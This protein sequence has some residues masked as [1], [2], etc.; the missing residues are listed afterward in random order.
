M[1][2]PPFGGR[3]VPNEVLGDSSARVG[4]QGGRATSFPSALGVKGIDPAERLKH[5]SNP[6][7]LKACDNHHVVGG[8]VIEAAGP[9]L[10]VQ[11]DTGCSTM[12]STSFWSS[13]ISLRA[14]SRLSHHRSGSKLE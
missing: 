1:A 10:S 11:K 12:S 5:H 4:A 8:A 9:S 14:P 2:A 3:E 7:Y 13:T 6:I